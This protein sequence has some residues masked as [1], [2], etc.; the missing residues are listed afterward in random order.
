MGTGPAGRE[1]FAVVVTTRRCGVL[2]WKY[3]KLVFTLSF[4]KNP[5]A[6]LPQNWPVLTQVSLETYQKRERAFSEIYTMGT[7]PTGHGI[8]A[9]IHIQL[10]VR[11]CT[12]KQW[13]KS[14]VKSCQK[15]R[16]CEDLSVHVTLWT[17]RVFR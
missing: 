8:F 2:V 16:L 17:S 9:R 12:G 14:R 4:I 11:L 15:I 6:H 3:E 7:G 5:Y 1:I 10:V 13:C